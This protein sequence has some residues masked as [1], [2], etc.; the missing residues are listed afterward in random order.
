MDVERPASRCESRG[1]SVSRAGGYVRLSYWTCFGL[2]LCRLIMQ[3][4]P[5]ACMMTG[6]IDIVPQSMGS[7]RLL[8]RDANFIVLFFIYTYSLTF[9]K[10]NKTKK[11]RRKTS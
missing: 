2:S 8:F 3:S 9:A 5:L 1:V 11:K 4:K 7:L 6:P 10:N